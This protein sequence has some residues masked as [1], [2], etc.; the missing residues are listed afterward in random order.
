[1]ANSGTNCPIWQLSTTRLD[2]ASSAVAGYSDAPIAAPPTNVAKK[3][4]RWWH[5]I[6]VLDIMGEGA[7]HHW[8]LVWR[9]LRA[10]MRR[11]DNDS[12]CSSSSKV[13]AARLQFVIAFLLLAC[14][15]AT[16]IQ[17]YMIWT[18]GSLGIVLQK[19]TSCV[20]DISH[21][22]HTSRSSLTT[23]SVSSTT[24]STSRSILGVRNTGI[25]QWNLICIPPMSAAVRH[26]MDS[27]FQ[28]P[29]IVRQFVVSA[30]V[31]RV[32]E[33]WTELVACFAKR[34]IRRETGCHC[35]RWNLEQPH[36][37]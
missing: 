19:D 23:F 24:C 27:E 25:I 29:R 33:F 7:Q 34:V 21:T 22:W 3:D 4:R 31:H 26:R 2:V 17:L 37:L 1:M 11:N 6:G 28:V 5:G 8:W 36:D 12:S 32:E 16:W 30:A 14:Y 13:D 18:T 20:K 9:W 10:E 15:Q 35:H